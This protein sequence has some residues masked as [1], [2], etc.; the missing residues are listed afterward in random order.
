MKSAK[1]VALF[2]ALSLVFMGC[3]YESKIPLDTADKSKPDKDFVGGWEEKGDDSYTW[4]C[5]MDGNQYRIE[6]KSTEDSESEP[7]IYIGW[8]SDVGGVPFINVYEQDYSSDRA[9]YLYR[10]DKKSEDRIK[11]KAITDNITEEF[12]TSEELKTFIKKNMELSF[13]YNKDDEKTFYK[14]E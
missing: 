13:F 7:T 4:K 8:L 12:T 6:K 5:T 14:E 2:G 11:F 9:Y 10:V 3:P 1:F